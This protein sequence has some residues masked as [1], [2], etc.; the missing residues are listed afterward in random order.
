MASTLSDAFTEEELVTYL[1]IA[2]MALR[3]GDFFDDCA[4]EMDLSD[5]E[6]VALRDKLHNKYMEEA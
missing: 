1:E 6:M 2:R 5:A 3:D 4:E